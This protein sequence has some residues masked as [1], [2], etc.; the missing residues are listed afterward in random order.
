V[1]TY[2]FYPQQ[3]TG[4]APAFEP[5]ELDGDDDAKAVARQVLARHPTCRSVLVCCGDREVCVYRDGSQ[6]D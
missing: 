3:D 6:D 2:T 5:F 1:T 4:I